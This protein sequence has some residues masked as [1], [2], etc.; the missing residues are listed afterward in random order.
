MTLAFAVFAFSTFGV[1]KANAAITS[2]LS[3]GS[4]GA[5]V[6]ELQQFLATNPFVYPSGRV[7]G[8]FGPLTQ[9]AVVQFQLAYNIP[10]VGSVGPLTRAKISSL[11]NSESGLDLSAPVMSMPSVQTTNSSA[12]ISWSTNQSAT[13]KVIYGIIPVVLGNTFDTTGIGF[14]E[15]VVVG[16]TLAPSD[17]VSRLTQSVTIGGLTSNTTYYYVVEAIDEAHNVS[18]TL[19]ATFHTNS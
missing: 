3:I 14:V 10:T 15:P 7:T 13:G 16:G 18:V 12:T 6:T 5:Q 9:A 17:G 1:L 4:S 8:Y 2:Q 11:Q 19:P